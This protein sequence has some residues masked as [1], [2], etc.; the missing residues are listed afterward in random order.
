MTKRDDS[1]S[2]TIVPPPAASPNWAVWLV[3]AALIPLVIWGNP[4][5]AI[6]VGAGISLSLNRSAIPNASRYGKLA[7]QTAIVL[8]GANLDAATM[9][10]MSQDY[11]GLTALYVLLTL[12]AG[13]LLGR[14]LKIDQI[15]NRLL[16]AG[17]AICGGTAIATLSPILKARPDQLALALT[18][19]FCLN[20]VAILT[21]PVVGNWLGMTETQ[22]GVW[23][24]LAV[25]DTSSVM[26]TAAVYGDH[27]TE[28]AT[29]VKLGRTLWLI[30]VT[31]AFS[32]FSG[33][34]GAKIRIPGFITLFILASILGSVAKAY[35]V[36]PP[37]LFDGIKFTS[38]A[39]IVIALFF[40]GLE[41]TRETFRN[42]HGRVVSYAL[43]LWGTVVPLTLWIALRFG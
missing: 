7:L 41:F 14:L 16:A 19:V 26:A 38:Q 37:I 30:P 35:A 33:V 11:A 28:V 15:L 40:I 2:T 29:T 27:A 39:L 18:I 13:L 12:G 23:A 6:L 4:L 31:L 36:L 43:L 5:S 32:L 20:M 34:G 10:Q 17:T 24:A 9:W 42:L 21:F 25:H 1:D 22:F 8:L 3:P